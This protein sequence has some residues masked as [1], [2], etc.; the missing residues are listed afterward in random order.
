MRLEIWMFGFGRAGGN[1]QFTTQLKNGQR[2]SNQDCTSAS[3]KSTH[4]RKL[5]SSTPPALQLN[6]SSNFFWRFL[7]LMKFSLPLFNSS[8][9]LSYGPRGS[10]II[11]R[12]AGAISS[13]PS[14]SQ[15][16]RLAGGLPCGGGAPGPHEAL[17]G[18][19][20]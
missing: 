5:F 10:S 7:N 9:F 19:G 14:Y 16:H 6:S 12:S 18:M 3:A 1:T 11:T 8:N 20:S 15:T 4:A 2:H 17:N 13:G